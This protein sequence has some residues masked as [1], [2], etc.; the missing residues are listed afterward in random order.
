MNT[1]TSSLQRL[2]NLGRVFVITQKRALIVNLASALA[3][4]L[5]AYVIAV[6]TGGPEGSFRF[7]EAVF[8]FLFPLIGVIAASQSFSAMHKSD[9]S[10]AYLTLPASHLEKTVEK[11]LLT[12]V[13]YTIVA[14]LSYFI[15][16]VVGLGLGE[17]LTGR[18]Y[19]VFNPG[20]RWVW[21]MIG[22]YVVISSVFLFGAAYFRSRHFIKTVLGVA[23]VF[24]LIAGV[25][26]LSTWIF[27][28]DIFQAM[29]AGTFE[30]TQ[31]VTV[32]QAERFQAA[33]EIVRDVAEF[34]FRWIMAPFF[35]ILTWLRV[36]EA[37]VAN[38]V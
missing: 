1:F 18:S 27:F 24:L 9:R 32:A 30:A 31:N 22:G 20:E 19:P 16:S 10:Y 37:E 14:L 21:Q 8:S 34:L 33:L 2:W 15:F 13:V 7:H 12:T 11:L 35:W 6:F 4:L 28:E 5:A 25:A 36:R 29:R 17:L 26:S 38:A 23:A 3:V